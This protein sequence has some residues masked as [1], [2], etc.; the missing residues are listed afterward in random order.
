MTPP[1]AIF[2]YLVLPFKWSEM[3]LI[4]MFHALLTLSKEYVPFSMASIV[5]SK[6][7]YVHMSLLV[8]KGTRFKCVDLLFCGSGIGGQFSLFATGGRVSL[9]VVYK[10]KV[11]LH[12]LRWIIKFMIALSFLVLASNNLMECILAQPRVSLSFFCKQPKNPK[13]LI[14][15]GILLWHVLGVLHYSTLNYRTLKSHPL[16]NQCL[17]L[18]CMQLEERC[19]ISNYGFLDPM[20]I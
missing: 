19:N 16:L 8:V 2:F 12:R 13:S 9:F 11:L 15:L 6:A 1:S 5:N 10:S 20:L 3:E 7:S 17:V 18:M 4:K 14:S